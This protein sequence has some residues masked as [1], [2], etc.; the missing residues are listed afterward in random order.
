MRVT[1]SESSNNVKITFLNQENHALKIS[2]ANYVLTRVFPT[3]TVNDF[4]QKIKTTMMV[5]KMV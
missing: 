2:E 4:I 3:K 5:N 1:C